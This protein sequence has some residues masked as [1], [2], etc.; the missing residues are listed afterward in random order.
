MGTH[1]AVLGLAPLC[2]LAGGWLAW[3]P[4][5]TAAL[6]A[7]GALT[8]AGIAA[9]LWGLH[10]WRR[11]QSA[12]DAPAQLPPFDLQ[13]LA[14]LDA[15]MDAL[16]P[17]VPA[18]TLHQLTVIKATLVRMAPLLSSAQAGDQFTVDDG[19]YIAECVR[20][21]LPDSLQACLRVPAHLRAAG[22]PSPLALLDEQLDLL[23]A[24]LHHREQKLG[25][26]TAEALMQQRRFL[27]AKHGGG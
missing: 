4:A 6:A 16:A 13:A 24:E 10:V 2:I 20:R 22:D 12:A 26:A 17:Q 5:G 1:H 25:R 9:G 8:V 21:Y 11:K 23:H 18:H 27:K 14:R 19:L 15:V 3:P 7:G